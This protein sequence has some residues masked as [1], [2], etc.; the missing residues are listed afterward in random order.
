VNGREERMRP[1]NSYK[2][3]LENVSAAIRGEAPLLLGREDAL[4]QALTVEALYASAA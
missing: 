2:L 1:E 4:G 3:E